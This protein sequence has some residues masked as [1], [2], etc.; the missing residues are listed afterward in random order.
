MQFFQSCCE[1][2]SIKPFKYLLYCRWMWRWLELKSTAKLYL[3]YGK[4]LGSIAHQYCQ[5]IEPKGNAFGTKVC[6]RNVFL[7]VIRGCSSLEDHYDKPV[8]KTVC[9]KEFV[10][11][12][13]RINFFRFT[14]ISQHSIFASWKI[15][16]PTLKHTN[17]RL[18]QAISSHF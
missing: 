8:F 10:L 17:E 5:N 1:L 7:G 4:P 2:K 9:E 3:T 18:C 12:L 11:L 16:F 14:R 13:W 15:F 6:K